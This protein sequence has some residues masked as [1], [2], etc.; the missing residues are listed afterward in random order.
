MKKCHL[1]ERSKVPNVPKE[2]GVGNACNS[3]GEDV[4]H[5]GLLTKLKSMESANDAVTWVALIHA[6]HHQYCTRICG[7][8]EQKVDNV[9]MKCFGCTGLDKANVRTHFLF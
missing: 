8:C 3:S 2:K 4:F 7:L 1:D 9:R 6:N 5:Q